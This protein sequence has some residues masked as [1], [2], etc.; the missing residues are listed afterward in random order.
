M[1]FGLYVVEKEQHGMKHV[2]SSLEI[3]EYCRR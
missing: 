1:L 3:T 2:V